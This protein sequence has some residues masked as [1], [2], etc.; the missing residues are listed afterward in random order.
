MNKKMLSVVD[1]HHLE[2][3]IQNVEFF[4]NS[5]H[6]KMLRPSTQQEYIDWLNGMKLRAYVTKRYI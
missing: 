4:M 1:L 6:F 2:K 3:K 5:D